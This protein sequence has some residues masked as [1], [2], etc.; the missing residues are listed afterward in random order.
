MDFETWLVFATASLAM[1]ILP[2]PGVASIIGFA[3]SSGR[4]TA[5]A[6][7]AGMAVGNVI[8]MSVS[9]AGAGMILGVSAI[10]FTVLKWVGALYL[11]AIGVIAI[12][13][14]GDA[15]RSG[16]QTR[17]ISARVAFMTNVAVGTF[18]PKTIVFFVA[19]A[20]QFLR[21]DA[22]YLPQAAALIGT[23]TVITAITDTLYALT[24][25]RASGLI[26]KPGVR[27][28]AQRAG[29]GVILSAGVA[30]AAMRR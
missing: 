20:A 18:H 10:A 11:I 15:V 19:F 2:G 23:Y 21:E 16:E 4:R 3:F 28:W 24:A 7:V 25:A 30:M 22:A 1:G 27:K 14:S 5:L 13:R 12:V 17:A 8:A 9:L 6:S 26:R 29:G